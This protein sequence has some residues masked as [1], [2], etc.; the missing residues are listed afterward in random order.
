MCLGATMYMPPLMAMNIQFAWTHPQIVV[1][2]SAA[3]IFSYFYFVPAPFV[4]RHGTS[5]V[6]TA[7]A[8]LMALSWGAAAMV[9]GSEETTH[10]TFAFLFTV[11]MQAVQGIGT[12]AVSVAV[13]GVAAVDAPRAWRGRVFG[14]LLGVWTLTII[15]Y[16]DFT[17]VCCSG[18]HS[19]A[20]FVPL[21][22]EYLAVIALVLSFGIRPASDRVA[23]AAVVAAPTSDDATTCEEDRVRARFWTCALRVMS[24]LLAAC[25]TIRLM[26]SADNETWVTT[27]RYFSNGSSAWAVW[28]TYAGF[29]LYLVGGVMVLKYFVELMLDRQRGGSGA[30]PPAPPAPPVAME[31]V[32]LAPAYAAAA[33][34]APA[35]A[36][37]PDVHDARPAGAW[38]LWAVGVMVFGTNQ[39]IANNW[40]NFIAADQGTAMITVGDNPQIYYLGEVTYLSSVVLRRI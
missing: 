18:N 17:L 25:G 35:A 2:N 11:A 6:A 24:P 34:E 5:A 14:L 13:L 20:Y 16:T 21:R 30:P 15:V 28:T 19:A 8:L 22:R 26:I 4:V 1:L 12:S 36:A 23:A 31:V 29:A 3:A 10:R 7:G 9:L 27:S 40:Y 39:M 32:T 37:A 38:T 33:P